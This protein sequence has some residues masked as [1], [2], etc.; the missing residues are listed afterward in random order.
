MQFSC[1]RWVYPSIAFQPTFV[2]Q[3]FHFKS[4]EHTCIRILRSM[5]NRFVH[6]HFVRIE[7]NKVFQLA[8]II[9]CCCIKIPNAP[10][11]NVDNVH[12]FL[13]LFSLLFKWHRKSRNKCPN[14]HDYVILLQ[15]KCPI[16]SL[17]L[18]N[19]SRKGQ[20]NL[21]IFHS[22]IWINRKCVEENAKNINKKA[23]QAVLLE[24]LSQHQ[25]DVNIS[26]QIR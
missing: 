24:T 25:Y 20:A 26:K 5:I 21:F 10:E 4:S 15:E 8:N 13:L 16:V 6:F 12:I 7:R 23:A 19:L 3:N 17:T 9:F 2:R 22:N 14:V 11:Q 1:C 18:S